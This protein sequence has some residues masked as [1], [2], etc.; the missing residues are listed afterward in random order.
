MPAQQYEPYEPLNTLKSIGPDIW[1][2]DGPILI[3][4]V[5]PAALPFPTRMTL[6][7]LRDGGLWVHSPVAPDET[8]LMEI[9]ALG[10]V[11]HLVSSNKIH[12][13]SLGPWSARYPDARVWASPGVRKRS[14]VAFTDDLED[15]PPGEWSEDIDQR[16]ARGSKAL[17]EVVFFHAAS[18]TLIL[19]DLIENFE[20]DRVH[21]GPFTK[22]LMRM[23]GVMAPRGGTPRDLRAS[24]MGGHEKL[25]PVVRWMLDCNPE[26]VVISHGK[27]FESGGREIIA[28][29]FSWVKGV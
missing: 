17:E 11:R 2:A 26:K 21:V 9:D 28:N 4:K 18:R 20:A 15:L 1:I 27:W 3:W 10:P 7:R 12:H 16:I 25:A 22:M 24:F 23:G 14:E 19:T 5:G 6:V 8:L 29:A 13:V